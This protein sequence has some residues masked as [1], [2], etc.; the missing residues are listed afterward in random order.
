M[1]T[2]HLAATLAMLWSLPSWAADAWE[3]VKES[4][5]KVRT[6]DRAG[7]NVKEYWAEGEIAAPAYFVQETLL[8]SESHPRVFP[9][10]EEVKKLGPPA[11]DGTFETYTLSNP[12]L[13]AR[14]DYV[15]KVTVD[16]RVEPN[17]Q[18][19]YRASWV[20]V[21]GRLPEKKG[22]VRLKIVEGS[23]EL[24]PLGPAKCRAVYRFALD[25]AGSVPGFAKDLTNRKAIN[26]TYEVL[27][28]EA[29]RRAQKAA[30]QR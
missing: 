9:Y 24:F 5:I 11:A 23:W 27:E 30:K 15:V 7:S 4:P 13:V 8:D 26:E 12:P 14:R 25:P 19:H 6:R 22:V 1:S 29:N 3:V 20:A 28:A 10:L 2:A 17:G 16:S 18:G 21:D